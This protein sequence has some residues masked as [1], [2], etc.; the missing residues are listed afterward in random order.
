MNYRELRV[1]S[2]T[3]SLERTEASSALG[4]ANRIESENLN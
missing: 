1:K 3:V 2:E 4:R